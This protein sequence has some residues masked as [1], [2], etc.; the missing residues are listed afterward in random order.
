MRSNSITF[1]LK[2]SKLTNS[3]NNSKRKRRPIHP[4]TH[5]L[6]H[7]NLIRPTSLHP[8]L[9]LLILHTNLPRRPLQHNPSPSP[10]IQTHKRLKNQLCIRCEIRSGKCTCNPHHQFPITQ[11]TNPSSHRSTTRPI[12]TPDTS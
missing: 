7:S 4:T 9:N 5:H 3:T 2:T 12:S 8:I 11:K 10:A 1:S 6:H